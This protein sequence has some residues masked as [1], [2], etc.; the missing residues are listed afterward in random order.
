[1]ICSDVGIDSVVKQ[2]V[3]VCGTGGVSVKN[4]IE[5]YELKKSGIE[6]TTTSTLMSSEKFRRH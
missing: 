2:I 6:G 1:M 5:I 4:V 3:D